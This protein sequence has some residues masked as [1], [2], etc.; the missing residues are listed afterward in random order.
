MRVLTLP[1]QVVLDVLAF[2]VVVVVGRGGTVGGDYALGHEQVARGVLPLSDVY[3]HSSAIHRSH[4]EDKEAFTNRL[5]LDKAEMVRRSRLLAELA[6]SH[7]VS[8]KHAMR[9]RE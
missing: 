9:R 2:L 1:L 4:L 6:S 3:S 8:A 7:N 5:G